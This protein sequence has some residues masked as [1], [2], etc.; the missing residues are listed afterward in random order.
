VIHEEEAKFGVGGGG[1]FFVPIFEDGVAWESAKGKLHVG[2]AGGEPDVAD[3]EIGEG[4]V[5]AI[6]SDGESVR[7][8]GGFRRE[9]EAEVAVGVDL[10]GNRLGM[11]F[12]GEVCAGGGPSPDVNGP[13][14]LEDG[15]VAEQ[16]RKADVGAEQNGRQEAGSEEE[17][18]AEKFHGEP[19]M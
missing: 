1:N 14:T 4:E 2:L 8:A 5:G 9:P 7:T 11:K 18:D 19:Q 15:V 10:G 3:E 6:T 17:G 13:I 12:G 16:M